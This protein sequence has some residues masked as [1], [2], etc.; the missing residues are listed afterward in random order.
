MEVEERAKEH[1]ISVEVITYATDSVS[2]SLECEVVIN[3][4]VTYCTVPSVF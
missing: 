2:M 3:N 4:E 1:C